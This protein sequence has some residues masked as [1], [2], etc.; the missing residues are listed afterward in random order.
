MKNAMIVALALLLGG[1]SLFGPAKVDVVSK[2]TERLP[3][4]ITPPQPLAVAAPRWIVITPENAETV[5]AKMR[6]EGGN[7]VLF[8]VT[9]K[10]YEQLSGDL[11]EIRTYIVTQ[12]EIIKQ[13]D[14]YYSPNREKLPEESK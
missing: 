6:A 11:A 2:P 13:Y 8:G 5:W 3:L 12:R 7:V 14:L 1:C 9:D 10:G 4:T